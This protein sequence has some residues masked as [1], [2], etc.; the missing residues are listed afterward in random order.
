MKPFE[1]NL[2]YEYDLNSD[3]IVLDCGFYRG[4][5]SR[6]IREKHPKVRIVAFEPIHEFYM[7]GC[8]IANKLNVRLYNFGLGGSTR[9]EH[10]N[11]K[12]DMSGLFC[13]GNYL[14]QSFIANISDVEK[15]Y[16]LKP[17]GLFKINIEGGEFE[18][19][20]AILER[21]MATHY[22]NI[23]VQPHACVPDAEKRWAAIQEGLLKTHHLTF[24]SPWCWQNYELNK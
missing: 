18:L 1:E 23:Q 22:E 12:G 17:V 9:E 5:F 11:V 7:E 4:H 15:E 6:L 8:K 19:L 13:T 21:G 3:A 14:D 16:L 20:E 2:R 24:D 10:F